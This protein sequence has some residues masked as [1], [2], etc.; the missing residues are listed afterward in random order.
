MRYRWQLGFWAFLL[1]RISGV[2]LALYLAMHLYVLHNLLKGPE[3][4]DAVMKTVQNPV[5]KFFELVLLGGVLYHSI[6][7]CS[8]KCDLCDGDPTCVKF[9]PVEALKFLPAAEVPL[10][11][12]AETARKIREGAAEKGVAK[13]EVITTGQGAAK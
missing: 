2:A 9:C 6:K 5:F 13:G 4:F 7:N 8:M 1:M 12:R 10:A 3:T 11:K